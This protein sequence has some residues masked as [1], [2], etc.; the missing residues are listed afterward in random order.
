MSD[1]GHFEGLAALYALGALDGADLATYEI[2]RRECLPC[3]RA[4][5]EFDRV[6][7]GLAPSGAAPES[8]KAKVE[9]VLPKKGGE[10][11]NIIT[12]LALAAVL[13]LTLSMFVEVQH[14]R[15][16]RREASDLRVAQERLER[17][18]ESAMLKLELTIAEK[19]SLK[20][21]IRSFSDQNIA[22]RSDLD[23]V[24]AL[25]SK[26]RRAVMT[27]DGG[28]GLVYLD[29]AGGGVVFFANPKAPLKPGEHLVLWMLKDQ[30]A[31]NVAHCDEKAAYGMS[32]SAPAGMS[33]AVQKVAISVE[34][35]PAVG[36]PTMSRVLMIGDVKA[37]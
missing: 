13:L 28:T 17:R 33:A 10:R 16:V 34:T 31:L 26:G 9:A 12:A 32:P 8:L 23:K 5:A 19:E 36:S 7:T 15:D 6:A 29:P 37:E 2:H 22:L 27:G 24:M 30:E 21:A 25:T 14:L 11:S 4:E 3:R 1:H 35:D 20:R 18:L